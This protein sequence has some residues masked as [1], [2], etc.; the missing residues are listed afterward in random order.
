MDILFLSTK[1]EL[2]LSTNN[3]DPLS[4]RN[5]WKD[6]QTHTHSS[7]SSSISRFWGSLDECRP[8][9]YSCPIISTYLLLI[10]HVIVPHG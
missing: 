1:F 6:A 9:I 2:D 4:D 10:S 7:S 3:G 5:Y 8:M